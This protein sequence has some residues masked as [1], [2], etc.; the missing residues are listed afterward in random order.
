[1][2]EPRECPFCEGGTRVVLGSYRDGGYVENAAYVECVECGA[3]TVEFHDCVPEVELYDMAVHAWNR[4]AE[5]VC[6]MAV[7]EE[8]GEYRCSECGYTSYEVYRGDRGYLT[9]SYC[10]HCGARVE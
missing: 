10:A 7:D 1:M 9:P 6:H 4:R 3:H 2:G 5:H 8:R